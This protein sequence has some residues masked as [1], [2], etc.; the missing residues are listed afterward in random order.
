V[1]TI[2]V[3]GLGRVGGTLAFALAREGFPLA[4][5]AS[6]DFGKASA[7]AETIRASCGTLP[8]AVAAKDILRYA[9]LVFL[10]TPDDAIDATCVALPWDATKIAV[11]LSGVQGME[12]LHAACARGAEVASFHPLNSFPKDDL[13]SDVLVGQAGSLKRSFIALTC[14]NE[15]AKSVL[16]DLAS[17]LGAGYFNIAEEQKVLYHA[18][19]V[20]TS[21]Y[22]PTLMAAAVELWQEMG[23]SE[24]QALRFA[25]PLL[26]TTCQNT[27]ALGPRAALTGP[28]ARGDLGTIEKHLSALDALPGTKGT[29]AF[30]RTMARATLPLAYAKG[31]LTFPR[32]T[33][34]QNL[35]QTEELLCEK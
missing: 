7:F 13:S 12:V 3:V 24:E 15:K 16:E 18:A 30:Y 31:T 20:I 33:A 10:A 34:L 25:G 28:I 8:F 22:L 32:F 2:G 17:R 35:L 9:D 19:A 27:L 4:A 21:N 5:V 23:Y 29:A 11:H 14:R 26:S 1:P 6:R